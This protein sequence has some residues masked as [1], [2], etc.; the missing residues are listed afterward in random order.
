MAKSKTILLTLFLVSLLFSFGST[1]QIAHAQIQPTSVYVL[2]IDGT[3]ELGLAQ[4]VTR[5]LELAKQDNAAIL[6]EIN[7]FGGRVDAATEIRDLIF[8]MET[9]VI[10]FV[11]ERA[12]S[13]GA[14]ISIAAPHI[15][16][17]QGSSIGAAE[18]RPLDEKNIAYLR[19]EF[20]STA[21]RYGRDPQIAGAMVDA[22]IIIEGLVDQGQILSLTANQAYEL[23]YADVVANYRNQVLAH[24]DLD[25]LEIVEIERNWAERFAGILTDPTISQLL[26]TLGFLGLVVELI[27]PGW[28]V[29]GILGILAM[30]LFFGGRIFSGLAGFEVMIF[31][32]LGLILLVLEI[33]VIPGFGVVG[34]LGLLSVFGS[35]FLSY[36]NF[37]TALSSI[38]IALILTVIFLVIFWKR[39]KKSTAFHRFVLTT[40]EDKDQ[41]YTGTGSYK[42]LENKVGVTL[43]LL[44]PVGIAQIEGERYDVVSEV[45]SIPASTEIKVVKVE[46]NRIVVRVNAE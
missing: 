39:F 40:R 3:I 38:I 18:P 45:G 36:G 11:R 19:S 30:G 29:P 42:E 13:A 46:G 10:A 33:F 28:G 44:R 35:I 43:S 5:G 25:H 21:E 4:Y 7:T 6:L 23:G 17:A 2:S 31:F 34:I 32:V 24:Y 8:R 26:L 12:I 9:P 16:M 1:N 20:E 41:G 22:N 14:L 37:Y 27:S 15:S